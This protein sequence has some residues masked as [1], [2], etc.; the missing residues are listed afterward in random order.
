[1]PAIQK[2]SLDKMSKLIEIA[3]MSQAE[4]RF[5]Q[6]T[7]SDILRVARRNNTRADISGMMLYWEGKVIQLHLEL[8]PEMPLREAH[9]ISVDVEQRLMQHQPEADITI[10]EDP[11]GLDAE[12]DH[13]PGDTYR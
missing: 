11:A 5:D 7:L 8:D 12:D 1:M 6:K 9:R 3:Y 2:P 13:N 10:H 4:P